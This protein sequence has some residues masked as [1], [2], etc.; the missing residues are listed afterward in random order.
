[1]APPGEAGE[2]AALE[3]ALLQL[4]FAADSESQMRLECEV[5]GSTITI[6]ERRAPWN[7]ELASDWSRQAIAQLRYDAATGTWALYWP[8]HTGR[9]HRYEDLAA[10]A[11]VG[12]LLAEVDADPDGV[13]WG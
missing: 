6:V 10:A 4:A 9:W 1:M 7:A 2:A 3:S 13:F 5:R 12:P 11:D 8:R